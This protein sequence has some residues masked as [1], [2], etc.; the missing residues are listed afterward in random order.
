METRAITLGNQKR[1]RQSSEPIKIKQMRA[2]DGK[3]GKTSARAILVTIG[4]GFTSDWVTIK[5]L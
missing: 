2:A 4:H 1:Q 5:E 3:R